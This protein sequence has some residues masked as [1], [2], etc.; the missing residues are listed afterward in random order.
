MISSGLFKFLFH[1]IYDGFS[2]IGIN[3]ETSN[4]K[5]TFYTNTSRGRECIKIQNVL[6]SVSEWS[7]SLGC[8]HVGGL[9]LLQ[10]GQSWVGVA[11]PHLQVLRPL[12]VHSVSEVRDQVMEHH[13][14]HVLAELHQNEPVT[15]PE[16]LH[17]NCNIPPVTGL[18]PSTEPEIARIL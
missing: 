11:I 2:S 10:Q 9:G 14:V 16:L 6:R 1:T 7:C 3:R 4:E 8:L 17:H 12:G 5:K 18:G 13:G 15:K